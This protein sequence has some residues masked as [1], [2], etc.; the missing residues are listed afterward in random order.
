LTVIIEAV[1]SLGLDFSLELKDP[2][3]GNSGVSIPLRL[4]VVSSRANIEQIL[5]SLNTCSKSDA[6]SRFCVRRI[7]KVERIVPGVGLRVVVRV[8]RVEVVGG[9]VGRALA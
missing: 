1:E 8:E 6:G 9:G 3:V 5:G 4:T 2:L 7:I